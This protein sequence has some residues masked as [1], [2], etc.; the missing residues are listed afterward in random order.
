M[1]D[2]RLRRLLCSEKMPLKRCDAFVA[3]AGP[4]GVVLALR[5]SRLGYDVVLAAPPAETAH[6]FETLS[7]AALDQLAIEGLPLP[8]GKPVDFEIRWGKTSFEPRA[9]PARSLVVDRQ[10]L[11]ADLR[12]R[13]IESGVGIFDARVETPKL[14]ADGWR[15]QAGPS[16]F[17]AR[18][19]VDATGRRGM[20]HAVR[21][22]GASLIGLHAVYQGENLPTTA[23]VAAT[24]DG[25][26]WGAPTFGGDYAVSVFE[27]PRIGK[28]EGDPA[29]RLERIV[30]E[31]GVL[32]GA[33]NLSRPQAVAASDA[34]PYSASAFGGAG[35]FR[36]G[37]AA[38]A[39]DPLSS[40]G[41]SAALQSAVD[42]ALA[43]HTLHEEPGAAVMVKAFL[44]RRTQRRAARHAAW[45]AA[46]YADA[47][48]LNPTP[49]W[50][51]RAMPPPPAPPRISSPQLDQTVGL[52]SG[53]QI[54]DEPC[55]IGERIAM[56][57]VIAP[58]GAAEP[59]AF[60]DGVE[61]A[62]LFDALPPD[63]TVR[64]TLAL[65]S[66]QVG[67]ARAA[68]LF[69][70]AW[71]SGWL[72]PIPQRNMLGSDATL[73]TEARRQRS[74]QG[75]VRVEDREDGI[76]AKGEAIGASSRDR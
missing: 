54:H 60:A 34:T 45:T 11:H 75:A 51:T 12:R 33:K 22:R 26:I 38:L 50:L 30:E 66:R 6:S 59:V 7:P 37:D 3:G 39:L 46:L 49:F 69:A 71:R 44:D 31:T 27:D 15:L 25:W 48:A 16:A 21:R 40:S 58:P 52:G 32:D 5:L 23:R 41:V 62:P 63:A 43:I 17:G 2:C 57:R 20:A 72:A 47:A 53:I 61:L 24:R 4:A 10:I 9:A 42:A 19:L 68:R 70:W 8:N 14:T 29:S 36:I 73:L 28:S 55:P 13:A 1:R 56:R 65:W 67:G 18:V 64:E 35:L 74:I 76:R